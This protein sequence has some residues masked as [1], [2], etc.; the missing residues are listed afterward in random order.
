MGYETKP[1]DVALFQ[2]EPREGKNDPQHTGY[3]IAH[4]DIKAGER[5]SIRL[6]EK[7]GTSKTFGGVIQDDRKREEYQPKPEHSPGYRKP[8]P[9]SNEPPFSDDIPF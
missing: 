7:S 5:L 1:G 6:W 4:R 2:N 8:A 3:V 9:I